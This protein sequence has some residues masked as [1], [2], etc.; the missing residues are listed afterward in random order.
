MGGER[1]SERWRCGGGRW[2]WQTEVMALVVVVLS[3]RA[4]GCRPPRALTAWSA[5][6]APSHPIK[7]SLITLSYMAMDL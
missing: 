1:R 7:H 6:V 5:L 3:S 4:L 2:Q